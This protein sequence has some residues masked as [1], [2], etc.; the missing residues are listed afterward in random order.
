MLASEFDGSTH[1]TIRNIGISGV[2]VNVQKRMIVSFSFASTANVT[3]WSNYL[4]QRAEILTLRSNVTQLCNASTG[5]EYF[6]STG[7]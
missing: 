1:N 3:Q 6:E 4:P 5:E 2:G 7:K